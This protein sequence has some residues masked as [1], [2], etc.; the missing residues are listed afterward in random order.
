MAVG[1]W[2]LDKRK[3][4]RHTDKVMNMALGFW[5]RGVQREMKRLLK[6]KPSKDHNIHSQPGQPPLIQ[7]KQSPLYRLIL[8]AVDRVNKRVIIGPAFWQSKSRG[9]TTVPQR[10]ERGGRAV[11]RVTEKRPSIRVVDRAH[12]FRGRQ[13]WENARRSRGFLRWAF[14][15]EI[16]KDLTIKTAPRPFVELGL[17][18]YLAGTQFKRALEDARRRCKN[19]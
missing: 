16:K 6:K 18:K 12:Y 10:L 7:D 13:A 8:Y 15:R 11:I 14:D 1:N 19:G 4:L 2:R 5:G 3:I 17:K 9:S